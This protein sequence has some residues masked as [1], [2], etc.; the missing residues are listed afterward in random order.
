MLPTPTVVTVAGV[1]TVAMCLQSALAPTVLH[2]AT[3]AVSSLASSNYNALAEAAYDAGRSLVSIDLPGHGQDI[4]SGEPVDGLALWAWRTLAGENIVAAFCARVQRTVDH[5]ISEGISEA[6]RIGIPG[7]SRG[8]FMALHAL[9][10][11]PEIKAG[12]GLIP[13]TDLAQLDEFDG[14]HHLRLVRSTALRHANLERKP[15]FVAASL[16]D[17]RVNS[18]ACVSNMAEIVSR[19]GLTTNRLTLHLAGNDGHSVSTSVVDTAAAW[20]LAQVT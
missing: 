8:G 1:G 2:L 13:V 12:V 17:P 6:G 10:V 18:A 16:N 3:D 7:I 4:R 20:L 11:V 9:A 5:L 19:A 14:L 15:V